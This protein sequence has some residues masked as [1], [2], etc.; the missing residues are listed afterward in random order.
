MKGVMFDKKNQKYVLAPS[1]SID[2]IADSFHMRI[3]N[4]SKFGCTIDKGY[5]RI[6]RTLSKDDNFDVALLEFGGIAADGRTPLEY[7]GL[8]E[9][10]CDFLENGQLVSACNCAMKAGFGSMYLNKDESEKVCKLSHRIA[11]AVYDSKSCIDKLKMKYI[12]RLI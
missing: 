8:A 2:E 10:K 3:I 7:A 12:E 4:S 6:M 9:S 1:D 5:D 11:K